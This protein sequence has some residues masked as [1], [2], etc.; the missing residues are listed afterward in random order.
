[1]KTGKRISFKGSIVMFL[2]IIMLFGFVS[3][4]MASGDSTLPVSA[5]GGETP[6]FPNLYVIGW[7]LVNFLVLVALI[8]KFGYGPISNILEQR[9]VAIEGSLKHAEEVKLEIEKMK[10]EAQA[11]LVESRK[12]AQEIVAK[13][14]KAAE[15]AKNEIIAAGREEAANIKAKAETEIKAATEAAKAELRETTVILSMLAAEKVLGRVI[16]EADHRQMVQQ[17]VNEAGDLL[18]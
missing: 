17:F 12:E 1:M 9:S 2:T 10:I 11:N 5:P 14:S 6:A 7:S 15:D 16:T 8:Y 4:C 13:A 18:C 3:F